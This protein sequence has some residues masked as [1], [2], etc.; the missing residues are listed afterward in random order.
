MFEELQE[1]VIHLLQ[2][3]QVEIE[4]V[5]HKLTTLPAAE[6]SE[7]E[8]FFEKH[9]E[10]LERCKKYR[11]LFS[12]L[13]RHWN[14]LSPQL[15]HH[16]I[17]KLPDLKNAIRE[18]NSYNSH[19]RSFRN[20]TLLRL[21]CEIDREYIEPPEGFSKI[22]VKF[23]K[24]TP[25]DP[26]LQDVENFRNRYGKHYRLRSFALMLI[27]LGTIGSFIFSFVVPNSI[28]ERLKVNV[29]IRLFKR[30]GVIQ[31]EISGHCVYPHSM[32]TTTLWR[33]IPGHP[34]ILSYM[35]RGK[36]LCLVCNHTTVTILQNVYISLGGSFTS[37]RRRG[38]YKITCISCHFV[39]SL[40]DKPNNLLPNRD[41]MV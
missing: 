34:I 7:H 18:R 24:N 35:S 27:A 21:F 12:R 29:P 9:L 10:E 16:L 31:L 3:R 14:Y 11:P 6:Q 40:P 25:K 19:L 32:D 36:F 41:I 22:V 4:L 37:R 15:L 26:T 23:R 20:Q 17:D 1:M 39:C 38:M 2:L 8:L 30:F 33:T 28:L 5:V 13:N